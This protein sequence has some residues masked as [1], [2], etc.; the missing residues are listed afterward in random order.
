MRFLKSLIQEYISHF[1]KII[2][3]KESIFAKKKI[4]STK[5]FPESIKLVI[6][7][8][9]VGNIEF[10]VRILHLKCEQLFYLIKRREIDSMIYRVI[11]FTKLFDMKKIA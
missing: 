11:L 7:P 2:I 9:N 5:L 8:N 1:L 6:I 10:L 4:K 3:N